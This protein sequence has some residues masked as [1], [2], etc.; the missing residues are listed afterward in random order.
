MT[1]TTRVQKLRDSRKAAG[2]AE[3]RGIWAPKD[4]HDAFKRELRR[5]CEALCKTEQPAK[6]MQPEMRSQ[7]GT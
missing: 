5:V 3:V 1:S 2:L 7:D 4:Q 6:G